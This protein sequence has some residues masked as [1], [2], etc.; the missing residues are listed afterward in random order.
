MELELVQGLRKALRLAQELRLVQVKESGQAQE[1][2]LRLV[3]ELPKVLELVQPLALVSGPR[4]VQ[5]SLL[6]LV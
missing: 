4:W 3:Q 5:D 6:E 1:W 2:V